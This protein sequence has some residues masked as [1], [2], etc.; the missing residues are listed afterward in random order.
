MPTAR[1][2]RHTSG[3]LT[4]VKSEH[5][6]S[7]KA[8]IKQEISFTGRLTKRPRAGSTHSQKQQDKETPEAIKW[9]EAITGK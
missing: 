6:F 1:A 8:E 5:L 4:H 7:E 2:E 9:P 3:G